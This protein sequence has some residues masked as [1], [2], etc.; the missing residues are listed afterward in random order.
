M[1]GAEASAPN[2]RTQMQSSAKSK[3]A[4]TDLAAQCVGDSQSV[5]GLNE[6]CCRCA[7]YIAQSRQFAPRQPDILPPHTPCFLCQT[8]IRFF[9]GVKDFSLQGPLRQRTAQMLRFTRD[10]DATTEVLDLAHRVYF[11]AHGVNTVYRGTAVGA[12]RR[13]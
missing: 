9:D 13:A 6:R 7:K 4:R 5:A 8:S 3:A 11:L 1:I 12:V 2:G 10:E